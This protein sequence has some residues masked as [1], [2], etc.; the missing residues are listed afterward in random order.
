[1]LEF[2]GVPSL[3]SGVLWRQRLVDR[4]NGPA[5]VTII[6]GR[7]GVGKTTLAAQWAASTGRAGLW[8][9]FDAG[10]DSASKLWSRLSE[11]LARNRWLNAAAVPEDVCGPRSGATASAVIDDVARPMSE[12]AVRRTLVFD[13]VDLLG[14][15]AAAELFGVLPALGRWID[16]VLLTR[17]T[18]LPPG[19]WLDMTGVNVIDAGELLLTDDELTAMLEPLAGFARYDE[20]MQL[21]GRLP[22]A[23]RTA[24]VAYQQCAGLFDTTADSG[25]ALMGWILS[26]VAGLP[27]DL[28]G[29]NEQFVE[30]VDFLAET[31]VAGRVD[32]QL[33]AGLSGLSAARTQYYLVCAVELGFGRWETA[34]PGGSPIF[35]YAGTVGQALRDELQEASPEWFQEA[36]RRLAVWAERH[37][38]WDTAVQAWLQIC[39]LD[40]ANRAL[41]THLDELIASG[42]APVR[43]VL[44]TMEPVQLE[45]YPFLAVAAAIVA[46]DRGPGRETVA[47]D[48]LALAADEARLQEAAAGPAERTLLTAVE[49]VAPRLQGELEAAERASV[50]TADAVFAQVHRAKE[51]LSESAAEAVQQTLVTLLRAADVRAAEQILTEPS[52]LPGRTGRPYTDFQLSSMAATIRAWSGEIHAARATLRRIDR[53][54]P[55]EW[56]AGPAGRFYRLAR[57]IVATES[58]DFDQARTAMASVE[59][60]VEDVPLISGSYGGLIDLVQGRPGIAYE[61]MT[62]VIDDRHSPAVA[63][64]DRNVVG[65]WRA[66]ALYCHGDNKQAKALMDSLDRW[67][68]WPRWLQAVWSLAAGRSDHALDIAAEVAARLPMAPDTIFERLWPINSAALRATAYHRLGQDRLALAELDRLTSQLAVTGRRLPLAFIPSQDLTGLLTLARS[69]GHDRPA[70]VI[71][72]VSRLPDPLGHLPTSHDRR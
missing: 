42:G 10:V 47:H 28:P 29:R 19:I 63:R 71:G 66:F 44:S 5:A 22:V 49:T 48:L 32:P 69:A 50:K 17:N 43:D 18:G 35:R 51:R 40:A 31:A 45:G 2:V 24:V 60:G 26:A 30:F 64:I 39:D 8:V 16:C 33:A 54:W 21:V 68:P 72:D 6:R 9:A 56:R 57:L 41:S 58:L 65:G 7:P 67:P 20:L 38:H 23:A 1:M 59:P 11:E 4:L 55:P 61:Q 25:R 36:H 37:G 15:D 27:D 53:N 34:K 52:L 70:Q 12:L 3:P 13:N 14:A 46:F 62:K